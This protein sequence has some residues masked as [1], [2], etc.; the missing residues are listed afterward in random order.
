MSYHLSSDIIC[1]HR[2]PEGRL[3]SV[4]RITLG[5]RP[6]W[7]QTL[8]DGVS[9]KSIHGAPMTSQFC[10]YSEIIPYVVVEKEWQSG[11]HC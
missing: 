7:I 10:E 1:L 2:V 9:S 5:R 8:L 11:L 6:A 3:R 4:C